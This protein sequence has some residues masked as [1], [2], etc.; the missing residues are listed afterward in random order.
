MTY[1]NVIDFGAEGRGITRPKKESAKYLLSAA[2]NLLKIKT[3]RDKELRSLINDLKENTSSLK[4]NKHFYKADFMTHHGNGFYA[5]ARMYLKRIVN[6]DN[7]CNQEGLK[8]HYIADGCNFFMVDPGEY[9]GVFPVWDWAKIPGT[10]VELPGNFDGDPRRKGET[11]FVGGVSDGKNGIAAFDFKRGKLSARKACFFF[12]NLYVCLGTGI[13]TENKKQVITT[14]NQ[15]YLKG[16]IKIDGKAISN[17]S[18]N[19]KTPA[20]IYHNN[21]TYIFPET[22]N[23]TVCGKEQSGSWKKI[24]DDQS[25]EKFLKMYFRY[26]LIMA[27]RKKTK[28]ILTLFVL[29]FQQIILMK[30]I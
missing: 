26:G 21:V 9:E 29:I 25:G 8:N 10:T 16:K 14:I 17:K 28:N 13:S 7:F 15:C 1:G 6:T 30:L 12:E 4:G 27:H 18:C 22:N 20:E 19:I 23:I 3:G 24:N 2:K 5:S 11:D